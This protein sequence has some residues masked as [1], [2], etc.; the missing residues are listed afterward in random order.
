VVETRTLVKR[1]RGGM[2]A[3]D[4]LDL[5]IYAGETYGLLGPNG[6]GKTT[7]LRMLLGLVRPTSGLVRVFGSRPGDRS[8]L[9]RVGAMGETAFH[10]FLSGRDNLRAIARRCGVSNTRVAYVLDVV[11]LGS[12]S[13][14]PFAT[15]SLGMKQRLGVAAA[16]LKD[17]DLLILDEPS[18]GLDPVGRLEMRRLLKELGRDGRTIVLS[19]HDMDEV[20]R[21]CGRV[22]VIASGTMLAEG[23]VDQLRGRR[24]VWMRAQPGDALPAVAATLPGVDSYEI[25]DGMLVLTLPE[26][27]P[28][29]SADFNRLLVE[30]GLDV[31]EVRTERGSLQEAFLTLTAEPFGPQSNQRS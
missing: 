19:S 16:L 6:A 22:G 29:R 5:R 31:S 4:G 14:D 28:A 11:D 25:S 15:Y 26:S 18:N 8:A 12:R 10:P 23:T 9:S 24:R 2:V 27:D 20:E 1:F 3:V 17:P 30:A 7:T 21:L 13:R